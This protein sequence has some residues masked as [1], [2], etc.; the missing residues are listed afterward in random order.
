MNGP[1]QIK[2]RKTIY[3]TGSIVSVL[4]VV[5]IL[6]V[7]ALLA[8][9]HQVRWDLT[10]GRTQS[11]SP[12]TLNL[13]QQVD[14][15]LTLTAFLPEGGGEREGARDLLN[16]YAYHNPKV[17]FQILDPEREP[18]KAK[19]AGY[20]F[21]GNVL[22][23]YNGRQQMADRAEEDNVTNALRR[24][25]KTERK[26]VFFLT[27]HGERNLESGEK[28]G[29]QTAKRALEN[30]GYEVAS[31]NLVAQLQAPPD[32][33]VVIVA[34]PTKPLLSSEVD[35][36][37]AYLNRGGRLL[38]MLEA[39]QDG[40]LK[41]LLAGYGITLDDGV[42]L[43]VNQISQSL[44]LS[45]VWALAIQY[46][47]TPI[48]RDFQNIFTLYPMARPLTLSREAKEARL[49]PLVS[50]MPSSYEKLG[51]DWLK[52][53]KGAFDPMMDKKG[54]FTIGA[55]AEIKPAAA[56]PAKEAAA[57]KPEEEHMAYLAVYG[58][59]DFAAN[60]AF[61]LFGNGDLFLNTVNFLAA[62]EQQI[63]V[64]EALKAQLLILTTNQYYVLL[65]VG[66]IWGPLLMLVVGVWAYRT[67][68][69]RK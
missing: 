58:D 34:S 47:P 3:R 60:A 46:G 44:R 27:G 57:K 33:A 26:K 15:P 42:I 6:I 2:N 55:L 56:K 63:M 66:L 19:E 41:G 36:L 48:T 64:R 61:N 65:L 69:A 29:L 49:Q 43:D 4:L 18:L 9:W 38:V 25:L 37:K 8:D 10:R 12:V 14:K 67:R 5:G 22:L 68:R 32:A 50:T 28:D 1:D 52:T 23:N 53:G 7:A 21:P 39:F 40:G 24:I 62:E 45:P 20:R 31:L 59:M 11:L 54:P 35:S 16:R 17:S 30:E 13:L 51:K